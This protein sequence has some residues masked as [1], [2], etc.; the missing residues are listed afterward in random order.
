MRQGHGHGGGGVDGG[1]RGVGGALRVAR[2]GGF[3]IRRSRSSRATLVDDGRYPAMPAGRG[4]RTAAW[5]FAVPSPGAYTPTARSCPGSR[6]PA[7][8]EPAGRGCYAITPG[9]NQEAGYCLLR[10]IPRHDTSPRPSW[11]PRHDTSW[12]SEG[13]MY[14]KKAS[15]EREAEGSHPHALQFLQTLP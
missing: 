8:Q 7:R 14:R 1:Q 2:A 11:I 12:K 13:Y 3:S 5:P 15:V 6:R 9:T 4:Q 10:G